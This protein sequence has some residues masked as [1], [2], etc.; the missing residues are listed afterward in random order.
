MMN[1]ADVTKLVKELTDA[2][3][4]NYE[5]ERGHGFATLEEETA[6]RNDILDVINFNS[7][8]ICLDVGAGTGVF[9]RVLADWTGSDGHVIATDLSEKMLAK[10]KELLPSEFSSNVSFILG[11]AHNDQLLNSAVHKSFDYIACRQTVI[12]LVDPLSV[13]KQWYRLL[14]EN[15]RVIILDA[16]WARSRW[17]ES[18]NKIADY[19]PLA[20]AQSL[21]TVP[22]CLQQAGFVIEHC[23]LLPRVNEWF[24]STETN[25]FL[26][27][28][29]V[30]VA[31]KRE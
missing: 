7:G 5:K 11:D 29:Y 1:K 19:L 2:S 21:A 28:R 22:Y 23:Q 26:S 8:S 12:L 24:V 20:C 4:D 3:V 14:N 16:L 27:P 31:G 9:T 17:S 15:G 30:V 18:W 13:F 10:N 6:W 25:S